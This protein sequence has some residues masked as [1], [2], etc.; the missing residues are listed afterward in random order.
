MNKQSV[1]ISLKIPCNASALS[2]NGKRVWSIENNSS[3][4]FSKDNFRNSSLVGIVILLSNNV[5]LLIFDDSWD[6]I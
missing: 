3:L 5:S 2:V 1:S 6:E 4:R